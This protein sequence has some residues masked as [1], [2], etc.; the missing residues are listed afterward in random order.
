M[1]IKKWEN[2]GILGFSLEI[3]DWRLKGYE[4]DDYSFPYRTQPTL[5]F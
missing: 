2:W 1:S 5:S 4:I 3:A